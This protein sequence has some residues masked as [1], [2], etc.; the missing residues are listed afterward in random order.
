MLENELTSSLVASIHCMQYVNFVLTQQTS[1]CKSL[2][3]TVMVPE[4]QSQLHRYINSVPIQT[5]QQIYF[6]TNTQKFCMVGSYV[7]GGSC[8]TTELSK[9]RG[10]EMLTPKWALAWDHM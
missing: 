8:Y 4:V 9:L 7:F 5:V 2:L 1:P 6:Q 10:R 3:P